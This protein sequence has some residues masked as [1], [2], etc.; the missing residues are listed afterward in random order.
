MTINQD[1][2]LAVARLA[3]L[4]PSLDPVALDKLTQDFGRIVSYM[5][6]LAEV[7]TTGVTPMYSPMLEPLGPRPDEPKEPDPQKA[8]ALL[9]AAPE[10]SGRFFCVPRVV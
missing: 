9:A 1:T 8:E 2:A 4:D 7:D 5:D 10:R 3:R 6:I